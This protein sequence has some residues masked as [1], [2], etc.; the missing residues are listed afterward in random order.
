M[1]PDGP[2]AG[3]ELDQRTV[4]AASTKPCG[5]VPAIA[6]RPKEI[7]AFQMR[8]ARHQGHQPLVLR[9]RSKG[10]IRAALPGSRHRR[11]LPAMR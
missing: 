8:S 9:R 3:A 5:P 7:E 2:V 1:A 4:T 6:P 11:A 10:A